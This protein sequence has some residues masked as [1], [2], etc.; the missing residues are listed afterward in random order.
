MKFRFLDDTEIFRNGKAILNCKALLQQDILHAKG[1]MSENVQNSN[2]SGITLKL[3]E[4]IHIL[5]VNCHNL[6]QIHESCL[7]RQQM[8]TRKNF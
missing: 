5:D 1:L 8:T 6:E 4:C 3:N 2:L 7:C